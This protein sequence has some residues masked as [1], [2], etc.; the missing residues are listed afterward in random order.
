MS[1]KYC[2]KFVKHGFKITNLCLKLF[3]NILRNK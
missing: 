1:K 3:V 2:S